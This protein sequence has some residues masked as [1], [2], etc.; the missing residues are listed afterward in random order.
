MLEK[1]AHSFFERC[2]TAESDCDNTEE[3][4]ELDKYYSA[5]LG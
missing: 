2:L 4:Y 5:L 3:Q 1:S